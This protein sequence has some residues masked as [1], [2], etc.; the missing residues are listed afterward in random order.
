MK[1]KY[2]EQQFDPAPQT[3]NKIVLCSNMQD[4]Q[5]RRKCY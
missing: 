3:F 4:I 2:I 1:Y 5:P